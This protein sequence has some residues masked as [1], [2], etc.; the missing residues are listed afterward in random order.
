MSVGHVC[1]VSVV[2]ITEIGK[3]KECYPRED[4]VP[5][6]QMPSMP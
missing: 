1:H 3:I 5:G 6:L 4:S 2:C